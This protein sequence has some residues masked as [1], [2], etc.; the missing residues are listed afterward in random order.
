MFPDVILEIAGSDSYA[1]GLGGMKDW[2]VVRFG[3]L[4][5][6]VR[7]LGQLDQVQLHTTYCNAWVVIVPSRWDNFPQVV[8]DAMVRG[9]AIVASPHGGMPE[10]L[11]GTSCVIRDPYTPAFAENVCA[12]LADKGSRR[13]AGNSVMQKAIGAYSPE[14]VVQQYVDF[15]LKAK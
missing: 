1:R 3:K 11:A 9:K 4:I 7:F 6:N 14:R 15:V 13:H 12:F 8:L 2:L 5:R 10:M